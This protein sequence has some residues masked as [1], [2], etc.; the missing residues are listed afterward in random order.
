MTTPTAQ[1]PTFDPAAAYPDVGYLRSALQARDWPAVSAFFA[2]RPDPGTRSFFV[3]VGSDVVGSED[4]LAECARNE[5]FPGLAYTLLGARYIAAGWEIRTSK[6]AQYVSREQFDALHDH[7]RRAERLLIDATAADP[8]NVA[9]WYARL[10]TSM[11]LEM[12]KSES[13]RRYDRLA[14]YDPH[15]LV[16]QRRM[17]QLLCPK[18]SGSWD[19]VFGFARECVAAAPPG[20]LTPVVIVEAHTER[21]LSF[22]D[23]ERT[24]YIA[25]TLPEVRDAADR[26]VC[27]PAHRPAYGWVAVHNMFAYYF[28]VARDYTRAAYHFRV[29]G[30]LASEYPWSGYSDPAER[31]AH[32]RDLA[33]SKG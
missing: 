10:T 21:F 33:L 25:E 9:A 13:R 18:W 27:H 20:D 5:R 32:L 15:N 28:A 17:V 26:S 22:E 12:G 24:R 6:R 2:D 30:N 7:L 16:A 11:G 1:V 8:G 23:D 19:A 4:F 29:I 31:F 14:A 3:G